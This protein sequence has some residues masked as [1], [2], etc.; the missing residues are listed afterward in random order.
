MVKLLLKFNAAVIKE[1]PFDKNE[2]TIGRKSENDIVIDNPAVSGR[3][4]RIINQ[5]GSFVIEDL[6]S[7]N[8][9]FMH[10]RKILKANLHHKDEVSIAKHSLV[11]INEIEEQMPPTPAAQATSS[12]STIVMS[13]TSGAKAEKKTKDMVG[14]L[15]VVSGESTASQFV[16]TGLTTYIG[17]S[18]QAAVRIKGFF[19][20]DLAACI[21]RK[22]EGY[23]VKV[24][25]ER[26]I[27]VNGQTVKDQVSINPG[28]LIDVSNLKL[29]FFNQESDEVSSFESIK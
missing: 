26:S 4:A 21:Y 8:G 24:L 14:C 13:P 27:K 28:D 1:Y 19:A 25:K 6:N 10:D 23:Y 3:H 7:T 11:F 9:T 12:D 29:S 20:P 18:E 5:A 2:I 22:P 15:R 16:L 17:K